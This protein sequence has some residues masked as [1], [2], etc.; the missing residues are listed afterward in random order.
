[1]SKTTTTTTR[2]TM[3]TDSMQLQQIHI[4]KSWNK[5]NERKW[6]MYQGGEK[7][8]KTMIIWMKNKN[9][10]NQWRHMLKLKQEVKNKNKAKIIT[11]HFRWNAWKP[12]CWATW[13]YWEQT[14]SW[15]S[16][17]FSPPTFFIKERSN[18][19]KCSTA[20]ENLQ[21]SNPR[22]RSLPQRSFPSSFKAAKKKLWPTFSS[23]AG[24]G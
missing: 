6:I 16:L 18:G 17:F 9:P 10:W 15:L 3:S 7:I 8:N 19:T 20:E 13:S 1:M 5:A 2:E 4:S 12:H 14:L 23:Q 22:R 24:R 11:N 21:S